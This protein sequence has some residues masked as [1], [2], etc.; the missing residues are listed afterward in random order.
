MK[1]ILKITIITITMFFIIGCNHSNSKNPNNPTQKPEDTVIKEITDIDTNL[2]HELPLGIDSVKLMSSGKAIVVTNNENT[3]NEE[4][5]VGINVKN[6][7]MF[8]FGNG[9]YRSIMFLKNDGTVSALNAS[10]LI[11]N[12]KIE[13]M[14]N[15]GNYNNIEDIESVQGSDASFIRAKT[16]SGEKIILD[17]YIK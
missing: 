8:P 1:K 9:G 15:I 11:E 5:T 10:V 12:Q 6:I 17:E 16:T 2:N 4:L 13:I 3:P 14:D 7:Y